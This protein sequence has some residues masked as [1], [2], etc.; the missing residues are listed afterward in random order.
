MTQ[1]HERERQLG[2]EISATLAERLPEV[3]VLAVELDPDAAAKARERG[4]SP[5]AP[6]SE[7]MTELVTS[8]RESDAPAT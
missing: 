6:E 3:E 7:E 8:I 2:D 4:W 5:P 1:I